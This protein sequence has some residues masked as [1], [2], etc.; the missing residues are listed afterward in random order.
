M[1]AVFRLG[2]NYRSIVSAE[3]LPEE[4]GTWLRLGECGMG[5]YAESEA[6]DSASI[7]PIHTR[8]ERSCDSDSAS[9][10]NVNQPLRPILQQR[11]F[12]KLAHC[13]KRYFKTK[14]AKLYTKP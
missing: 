13:K 4:K 12:I 9:V 8:S 14:H 5:G 2:I 3:R 7:V 10:T 6:F 1:A 11:T